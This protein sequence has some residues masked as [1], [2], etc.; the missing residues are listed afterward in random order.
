M[1]QWTDGWMDEM[2]EIN[3]P[4]TTTT[5]P[6]S[7]NHLPSFA[8]VSCPLLCWALLCCMGRLSVMNAWL[9]EWL[10][11]YIHRWRDEEDTDGVDGSGT[12]TGTGNGKWTIMESMGLEAAKGKGERGVSGWR[13]RSLGGA[14]SCCGP[15]SLLPHRLINLIDPLP[16]LFLPFPPPSLSLTLRVIIYLSFRSI[17]LSD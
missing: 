8:V 2:D 1:V 12:G 13:P 14:W 5:T 7:I 9:L 10:L 3:A 11:A 17:Y 16:P 4:T 15:V 6:G